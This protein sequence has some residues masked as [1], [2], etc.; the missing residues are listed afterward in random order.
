MV[1]DEHYNYGNEFL[2][3]GPVNEKRK[4]RSPEVFVFVKGMQ[5]VHVS[6]MERSC[7]DVNSQ[8]F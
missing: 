7:L 2:R 3:L 1:S 5:K 8:K 4:A 6:K